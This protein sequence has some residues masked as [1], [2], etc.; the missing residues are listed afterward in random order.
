MGVPHP[1]TGTHFTANV[2]FILGRH[3]TEHQRERSDGTDYCILHRAPAVCVRACV[4][5]RAV[6]VCVIV[7]VVCVCVCVSWGEFICFGFISAAFH[8]S[9]THHLVKQGLPATNA[10]ARL[11][12]LLKLIR[13]CRAL[14]STAEQGNDTAGVEVFTGTL[15]CEV[16]WYYAAPSAAP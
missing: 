9:S 15:K 6:I 3:D 4:P 5:C 8:T 16:L 11:E 7:C 10:A 12:A 14:V 13:P 2:R 1:H